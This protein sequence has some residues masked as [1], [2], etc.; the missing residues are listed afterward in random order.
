[1][2]RE[3]LDFE[4]HNSSLL[5]VPEKENLELYNLKKYIHVF[6]PDNNFDDNLIQFDETIVLDNVK[7]SAWIPQPK[8]TIEFVIL[9]NNL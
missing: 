9:Y 3:F 5:L 7:D 6:P 8:A 4:R 1:M 2:T